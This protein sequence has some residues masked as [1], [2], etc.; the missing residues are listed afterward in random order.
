M[1]LF[2]VCLLVALACVMAAPAPDSKEEKSESKGPLETL[3]DGPAK[4]A[5]NMIG[6]M[7]PFTIVNPLLSMVSSGMEG[8]I[9]IGENM[10][11]TLDKNGK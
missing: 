10:A 9:D 3:I 11:K 8:M 7:K 4:F 1:K 2:I 6:F 5:K